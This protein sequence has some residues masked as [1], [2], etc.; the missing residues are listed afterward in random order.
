MKDAGYYSDKAVLS[1]KF[2]HENGC[3]QL[4]TVFGSLYYVDSVRAVLQSTFA[5][6]VL[7]SIF[8]IWPYVLIR[9]WFPTTRFKN[10]GTNAAGRSQKNELFYTI[11][12][13]MIKIFYLWA[14]Y[15]LGF[16]IN[17]LCF[18]NKVDGEDMKF[19]RGLFLLNLGTV[20]IS[21]FLHTLRF[22]KVLSPRL[23]FTLYLV[24][25]Y[26]TFGAIP[27]FYR[28][29]MRHKAL[30]MLVLLGMLC[31]MTRSLKVHAVWCGM[32]HYLLVFTEIDW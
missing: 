11:G 32:M 17:F 26:L 4:F 9:Q 2:V 29:F 15:F 19:I 7:E 13:K 18:L 12:T 22:K 27:F 6:R 1:R 16:Y 23:T 5:G 31:N 10:A 24:Q 30:G 8:V 25:I 20:S 14:K 28:M 3:Y 21:V